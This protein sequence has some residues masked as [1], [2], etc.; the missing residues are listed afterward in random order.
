MGCM[1]SKKPSPDEVLA[2]QI[3]RLPATGASPEKS[4]PV[5]AAATTPELLRL[6]GGILSELRQRGVSRSENS[7]VGDHAEHLAARAFGLTLVSNS[8]IGY[9]GVDA[10]GTRYQ[11]KGRRITRWNPSRQLSALRGLRG[12][13]DPFD[14]L[15]GILFDAEMAVARA[16][17]IPISVVRPRAA[18]QEHVHGSRFM[19][20]DA[21]WALPE[22]AD[23]TESIRA[24]AAHD[25]PQ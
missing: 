19:L 4:G 6:Y 23:V 16:A 25:A 15:L 14:M 12:A 7:P 21:V 18:W 13:T 22:V 1:A 11:V 20:T 24:A 3:N 9:D 10:A 8:S 5:L 2:A 17:L